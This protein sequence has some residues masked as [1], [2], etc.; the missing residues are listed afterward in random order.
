MKAIKSFGRF[1]LLLL[2][3]ISGLLACAGQPFDPPQTGEIPKGPGV[4]SKGDEGVVLFDS[5]KKREQPAAPK[6]QSETAPVPTQ[7]PTN[8]SDYEEFEA[9]Q[10][11]LEWKKSAAGSGEY[12][13]FEQWRQWQQ[14]KQWK[15]SQ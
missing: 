6:K 5:E 10:R 3:V 8:A 4:F 1:S 15:K 7:P 13:E 12:K 14:Y 11:W 2:L 9:Y